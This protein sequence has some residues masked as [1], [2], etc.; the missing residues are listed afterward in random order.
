MRP[1]LPLDL[2]DGSGLIGKVALF[3]V[4]AVLLIGLLVLDG[5]S[6]LLTTFKISNAAQ[7]AATAAANEYK[8]SK[9]GDEACLAAEAT[10]L[11]ENQ[12]VPDNDSWCK[13]NAESGRATISLKAQAST[14]VLGRLSFT[15]DYTKVTAKE[16]ADPPSL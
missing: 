16:S 4:I 8:D 12:P 13:V 5:V 15:R 2:R 1:A 14:L 11:Q 7:A 3:W 6:I 9:D 10:L